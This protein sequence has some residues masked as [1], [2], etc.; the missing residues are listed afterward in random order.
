MNTLLDTH[1][2]INHSDFRHDLPEVLQ[3]AESALVK[4]LICVGYDLESSAKAVDLSNDLEMVWSA[5]G[6]HPH[7]ASTFT[8]EIE[9]EIRALAVG[10]KRVVAIG[11]TGLDYYRNLSPV[12]SQKDA[13]RRHIRLAKEVD[14][15]LI[16]HSRDAG[17]D[18]LAIL[19]EE[20]LP[21]RGAV[22]HCFSGDVAFARKTIDIGCML[23]LAGQIT[24]KN[25]DMLRQVAEAVPLDR[26]VLETDAPY[27]APDPYRGKRN[28]PAYVALIAAKLA[29]VRGITPDEVA[30]QTTA[31]AEALFRI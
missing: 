13:F 21:P 25:A 4:R 18:V 19:V 14:L 6:V 8:A 20:G 27:L 28:E 10:N 29:E 26:I 11:E 9:G 23:G 12:D 3:R 15:P 5:V 30:T 2:H 16:I 24:F 31:N 1:C 7:D 22:M 17:D